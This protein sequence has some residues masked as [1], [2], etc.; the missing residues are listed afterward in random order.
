M[1]RHLVILLTLL[2]TAGTLRAAAQAPAAAR[3]AENGATAPQATATEAVRFTGRALEGADG[4]L[5]FDWSGS[6][7]TFR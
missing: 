1:M 3:T 5:A 7:F 2:A 4:S 6:H